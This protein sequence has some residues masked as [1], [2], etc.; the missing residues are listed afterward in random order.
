MSE[1][2]ARIIAAALQLESASTPTMRDG[3]LAALKE[4]VKEYKR[5]EAGLPKIA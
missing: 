1:C 3:A 2:V 4:A 5:L